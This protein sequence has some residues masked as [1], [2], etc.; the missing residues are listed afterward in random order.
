MQSDILLIGPMG[1]GKTTLAKLLSDRLGWPHYSFDEKRWKYYQE[2]GYSAERE[3]QIAQEEGLPGVFR[4]W[5]QF[6]LHAIERFLE[7]THPGIFDFGG[8]ASIFDNETNFARL[9][10]LFEPY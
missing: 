1:T 6:D 10:T 8:A 9:R 5:K 2:V 3:T 7:E 4:Y